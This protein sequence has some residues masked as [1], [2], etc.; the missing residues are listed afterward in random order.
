MRA[1][2]AFTWARDP[3][4]DEARVHPVFL[5]DEAHLLHQ[6]VL[7]HLHILANY[8]WDAKAL[9]SLV[10]VGLPEMKTVWSDRPLLTGS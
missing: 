10:L 1:I 7:E 2:C 8:E 4:L 3:Q 6:D 9:L 5:L